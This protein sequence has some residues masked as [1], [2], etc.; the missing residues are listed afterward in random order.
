MKRMFLCESGAKKLTRAI[1]D[2]SEGLGTDPEY[3]KFAEAIMSRMEFSGW[4]EEK[5]QFI[6][7]ARGI[8]DIEASVS[9]ND[10]AFHFS[11]NGE[12]STY[13]SA[14]AALAVVDALAEL[15]AS[16]RKNS[17]K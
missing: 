4:S 13:G 10:T 9:G 8:G 6:F 7:G 14:D 11:I 3:K 16:V 12:S 5:S 15:A 2:G 17:G 1:I